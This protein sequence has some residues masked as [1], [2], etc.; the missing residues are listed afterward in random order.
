MPI[1]EYHCEACQQD[2]ECLV[3][4][5]D[6]PVCPKC[7]G[8][9]VNRLMS[10]CGFV[11]KSGGGETVTRSAGTSGCSGCAATSCGSCGH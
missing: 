3:L 7:N 8:E 11:S 4:G 6:T 9:N 2:F 1:Y 5:S 10:I